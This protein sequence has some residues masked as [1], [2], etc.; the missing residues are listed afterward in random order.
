MNE[1]KQFEHDFRNSVPD[2]V[3]SL[4]LI[5]PAI[6]FDVE[7]STQRFAPKNPYDLILYKEP[8][9]YCLELKSTKES[10][11]SFRGS[12]SMIREHQI[13]KLTEAWEK[14]CRAGFVLNFRSSQNTCY[15]PIEVFHRLTRATER[16]SLR[17]DEIL[18][19]G[20]RLPV[21]RLR[22]HNRYDLNVLFGLEQIVL[23]L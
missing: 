16:Q 11:I 6:G 3:Y 22:I 7:S 9:M 21:R 18:E 2:D 13:R 1:G 19:A 8:W 14:G 10:R 17:E 23:T 20:T 15:L 4:R 5:D 12:S